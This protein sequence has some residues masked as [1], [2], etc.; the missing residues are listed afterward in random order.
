ML[1]TPVTRHSDGLLADRTKPLVTDDAALVSSTRLRSTATIDEP[2]RR[3]SLV[4][5][6]DSLRIRSLSMPYT[7]GI[8][9][10]VGVALFASY[11][12]FDRDRAFYPTVVIVVAS[13]YVLFAAMSRRVPCHHEQSGTSAA[14]ARVMGT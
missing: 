4:R 13:Y 12:G 8:V 11:V 7:I 10:S 1:S 9:L 5:T 6:G 3:T 14:C 2:R